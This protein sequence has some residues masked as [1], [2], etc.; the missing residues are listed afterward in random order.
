[1]LRKPYTFIT[2]KRLAIYTEYV[3]DEKESKEPTPR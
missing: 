2:G 1:M 3:Q